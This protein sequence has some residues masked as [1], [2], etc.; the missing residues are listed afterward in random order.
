MSERAE[1]HQADFKTSENH[2]ADEQ[3]LSNKKRIH[4]GTSE[5]QRGK[6]YTCWAIGAIS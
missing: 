3:L 6:D 2:R 4:R 1:E 5:D